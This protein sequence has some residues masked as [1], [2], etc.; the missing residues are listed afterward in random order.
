MYKCDYLSYAMLPLHR[1]TW[2]NH[3]FLFF[4]SK[5]KKKYAISNFWICSTNVNYTFK[6]IGDFFVAYCSSP[7]KVW[8]YENM[9]RYPIWRYE[10]FY[11]Y[12]IQEYRL[13][14]VLKKNYYIYYAFIFLW[15]LIIHSICLLSH[16][17]TKKRYKKTI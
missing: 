6:N 1:L 9:P 2:H 15:V 7:H 8:K 10:L 16:V 3:V 13:S 5:W 12:W 4:I 17:T 11:G 14:C